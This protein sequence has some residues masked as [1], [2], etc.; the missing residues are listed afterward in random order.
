[1]YWHHTYQGP[2]ISK[3]SGALIFTVI[4]PFWSEFKNP[5]IGLFLLLLL[6]METSDISSDRP[7]TSQSKSNPIQSLSWNGGPHKIS[8]QNMPQEF[9]QSFM[10]ET[11]QLFSHRRKAVWVLWLSKNF[12]KFICIEAAQVFSQWGAPI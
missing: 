11:A 1:M 6:G 9:W 12:Y 7:V 8:L 2:R 5:Y 3:L 4:L 10:V